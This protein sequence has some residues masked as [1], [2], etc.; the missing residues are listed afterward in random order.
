MCIVF[1]IF[2]HPKYKLIL[3][4][5]RD[6]SL[7]RPTQ[8]ADYWDIDNNIIS[9]IDLATTTHINKPNK[10]LN[11]KKSTILKRCSLPST[12]NSYEKQLLDEILNKDNNSSHSSLSES[13]SRTCDSI[14]EGLEKHES[15][16][17]IYK[18]EKKIRGYGSWLGCTR[19]GLF[20]TLTN[21][22]E[23]PKS[24]IPNAISRGY[25]VRDFLLLKSLYYKSKNIEEIKS[26]KK[27]TP[28]TTHKK[29][30]MHHPIYEVPEKV[31]KKFQEE[32]KQYELEDKMERKENGSMV[33]TEMKLADD[34]ID[35][36]FEYMKYVNKNKDKYN[37][38]NL[39][40]GDVSLPEPS[41]WYIGNKEYSTT[42]KLKKNTVYGMSN[43]SL[44]T[45]WK[46]N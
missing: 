24:L 8:A 26:T 11:N 43:G 22:R 32:E 33:D 1:F 23:D 28:T 34:Q 15:I 12:I 19:Q 27:N 45:Y 4:S 29:I 35:F 36:P 21:F 6:E 9:A 40:V 13:L 41:V 25:L 31:W 16:K 37:G 14:P 3:A 42:E 20:S 17:N 18:T 39:I 38:F 5:N 44:N 10:D 46:K 7:K 30:R 2:G